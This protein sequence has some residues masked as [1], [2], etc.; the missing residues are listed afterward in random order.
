MELQCHSCGYSASNIQFP[1]LSR[2]DSAGAACY[3]KC[4]ECGATVYSD[5]VG[6]GSDYAT[7]KVW[8]TSK[9]RGQVFKKG[10]RASESE[11]D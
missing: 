5:E 6:D 2:A 3:R 8:G 1:Y 9:L 4:P 7:G 10:W 11:S